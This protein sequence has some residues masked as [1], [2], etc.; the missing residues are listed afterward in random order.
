MA[1]PSTGTGTLFW[2]R[3]APD[4]EMQDMSLYKSSGDD[5]L[6][7]AILRCAEGARYAPIRIGGTPTEI[8]W[9]IGYFWWPQSSRFAPASPTG[10]AASICAVRRYHPLVAVRLHLQGK[11]TV[12]HRIAI[13]GTTRD[14]KITESS[15]DPVLDRATLDCVNA[16]KYFPALHDG[17]PVEIDRTLFIKWQER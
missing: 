9:V 15:G 17:Q 5:Q 1:P 12:S 2:A 13:D 16:F 6:D 3:I 7:K 8:T 11:T 10:E 14:A 4:G